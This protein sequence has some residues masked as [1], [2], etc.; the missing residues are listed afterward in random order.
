LK[1]WH[2]CSE[3]PD[4]QAY[5][6]SQLFSD[7]W[8]NSY[9]DQKEGTRDDFRFC[10]MGVKGSWTPLHADVYRSYSWSTNIVG[11]KLW[12]FFPPDQYEMLKDRYGNL[13]YNIRNVDINQFPNFRKAKSFTVIQNEGETIFVPS[14]WFHQVENLVTF[15]SFSFFF[16]FA[17]N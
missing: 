17:F 13:V 7:D 4:Y 11:K 10:Y 9:W 1:D 5:S 8:L 2:I 12:T 14:S 15:Y 6:L 16:L 3:Y